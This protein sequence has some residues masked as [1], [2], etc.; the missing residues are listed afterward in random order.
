MNLPSSLNHSKPTSKR[1]STSAKAKADNDHPLKLS[2]AQA[3]M[4]QKYYVKLNLGL[5]EPPTGNSKQ[6]LADITDIDVMA[7][8]YSHDFTPFIICMSCK[9]G[10]AKALK[11]IKESFYLKGVMDY[12]GGHRGYIVF[13]KKQ[14]SSHAR[15]LASKLDIIILQ[16]DEFDNWCKISQDSC[17][18]D[19]SLFWQ[20]ESHIKYQEEFYK[21]N[22]IDSLR[23]YLLGDYWFYRDFR[24]LQNI[25]AHTKRV[26]D[27]LGKPSL[28]T[29]IMTLEISIHF[30]LSLL[31]LCNYVTSAGI[32]SIKEN[33]EAYLFGGITSLRSRKDLYIKLDTFLKS[34]GVIQE[35]GVKLPS[36]IPEYTDQLVEL[37]YRWISKPGVAIFVPQFLQFY[38]WQLIV[39]KND[40]ELKC[41]NTRYNEFTIKFAD[42]LINFISYFT[43]IFRENII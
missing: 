35:G 34:K 20:N 11:P 41:K 38:A 25:I 27:F 23:S 7:I 8:K 30:A 28:S 1:Q 29:R 17:G 3:F 43:N 40:T 10:E 37:V 9:G 42:D 22:Q 18:I 32:K 13:S 36:L 16:G 31:D 19:C 39:S 5:S 24:N 4:C 14:V 2:A 6:I 26:K 21:I 12:F 15:L 33:I